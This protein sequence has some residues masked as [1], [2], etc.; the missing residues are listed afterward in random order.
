MEVSELSQDILHLFH[1]VIV[2]DDSQCD[3]G[4][5]GNPIMSNPSMERVRDPLRAVS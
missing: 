4:L 5:I 3:E 1:M 2:N